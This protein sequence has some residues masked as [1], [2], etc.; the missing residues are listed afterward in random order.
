MRR[1]NKLLT[2]ALLLIIVAGAGIQLAYWNQP[3]G[4][5]GRGAGELLVLIAMASLALFS[6][7]YARKLNG[8]RRDWRVNLGLGVAAIVGIAILSWIVYLRYF[9]PLIATVNSGG[10]G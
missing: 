10:E 2:A 4:A 8:Q 5:G 3:R 9:G 1:H 7:A 6:P